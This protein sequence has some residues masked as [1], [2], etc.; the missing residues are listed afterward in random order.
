MEVRLRDQSFFS[1]IL[2]LVTESKKAD[3][4]TA[5]T[6]DSDRVRHG[7]PRGRG[8]TLPVHGP[9]VESGLFDL[10]MIRSRSRSLALPP[11]AAKRRSLRRL[12]ATVLRAG[13]LPNELDGQKPVFQVRSSCSSDKPAVTARSY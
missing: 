9:G 13:L 10:T 5:P 6:L 1:R 8:G 7:K 3:R 4:L 12:L 11:S 2:Q